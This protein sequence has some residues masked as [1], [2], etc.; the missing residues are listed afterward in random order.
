VRSF[1]SITSGKCCLLATESTIRTYLSTL[2]MISINVEDWAYH[3][4]GW[5]KF[6][7]F[8]NIKSKLNENYW[9]L[10]EYDVHMTNEFSKNGLL[11]VLKSCKSVEV[12][13]IWE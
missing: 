7:Q 5:A 10:L 1:K 9:K 8:E 3:V 4:K 2:L 11:Y 6:R 13:C 12:S